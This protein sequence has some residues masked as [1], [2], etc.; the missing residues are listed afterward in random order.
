ML[1]A[2][3][4][5]QEHLREEVTVLEELTDGRDLSARAVQASHGRPAAGANDAVAVTLGQ[6]GFGSRL[7]VQLDAQRARVHVDSQH[8]AVPPD[9]DWDGAVF[10]I[11]ECR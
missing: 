8:L 3:V 5:T 4:G 11:L 9:S 2:G 10:C 1:F 7:P 6:D